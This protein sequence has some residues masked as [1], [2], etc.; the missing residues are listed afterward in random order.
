[1]NFPTLWKR[2]ASA[3]PKDI[4]KTFADLT[5]VW[6]DAERAFEDFDRMFPVGVRNVNFPP[7]DIAKTETGYCITLAVAGFSKNDLEVEVDNNNVIT[8]RGVKET[9]P[10]GDYLIKGIATRQ[11]VRMW[12][13]ATE[14]E[15][16]EVKLADGLLTVAIKRNEPL[17]REETV[18][19]LEV[20][21]Q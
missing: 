14:D 21:T 6:L 5:S 8:I 10:T 7:C 2:T 12:Q 13:L 17:P 15:V 19:R 9:K 3:L 11:F 20:K 1:M 4:E 18:K 16:T